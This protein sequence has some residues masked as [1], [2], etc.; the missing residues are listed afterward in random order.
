[1]IGPKKRTQVNVM[2]MAHINFKAEVDGIRVSMSTFQPG[3]G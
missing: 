2:L 3:A 1:M